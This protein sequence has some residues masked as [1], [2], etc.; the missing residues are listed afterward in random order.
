MAMIV[1]R[2]VTHAD[3]GKNE[4]NYRYYCI[5]ARNIGKHLGTILFAIDQGA[6]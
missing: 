6:Y 3:K 5:I 1:N 4:N 2:K